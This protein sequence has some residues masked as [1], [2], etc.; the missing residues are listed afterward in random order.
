MSPEHVAAIE[1][2]Q[3]YKG[4]KWLA[5]LRDL[6]NTDKHMHLSLVQ[7]DAIGDINTRDD[8]QDA[9]DPI[10]EIP[11]AL[12]V[13]VDFDVALFETFPGG[14]SVIWTLQTLESEVRALIQAFE[15]AFERAHGATS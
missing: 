15:P 14:G 9:T 4:G 3:P 12:H 6:S 7:P 11:G 13:H 8:A 2:L 1:T 5:Q 10:F